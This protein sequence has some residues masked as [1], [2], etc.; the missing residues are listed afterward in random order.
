MSLAKVNN[1]E[2]GL[3]LLNQLS[4][5]FSGLIIGTFGANLEFAESQLF[6]L[7]SKSTTS[8]LVLAD[9]RELKKSLAEN[10][11]LGKLNRTY[12]ASPVNSPGAHHPKYL[13]LFGE[14]SGRLFVGSGNLGV[15][16]YASTGECFTIYEWH[17][18]SPK[19]NAL[20]FGAVRELID[21]VIKR[22]WVDDFTKARCRDFWTVASWIPETGDNHPLLFIMQPYRSWI[23][24]LQKSGSDRY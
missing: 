5:D 17:S 12:I 16:G 9:S 4:G 15:A 8:K 6:G 10:G 18:D 1:N 7:L 11:R 20:P 13:L 3:Q 19:E 23:N 24:S 21:N 14:D 2:G 22:D